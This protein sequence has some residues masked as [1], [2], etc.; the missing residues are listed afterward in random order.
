MKDTMMM[1]TNN[2]TKKIMIFIIIVLAIAF[3]F[4]D[5]IYIPKEIF[6]VAVGYFLC[7]ISAYVYLK[8]NE[9]V[10]K[11]KRENERNENLEKKK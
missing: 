1:K 10:V 3:V 6:W 4:G 11:R 2:K 7:P 9:Y 8:L 5:G